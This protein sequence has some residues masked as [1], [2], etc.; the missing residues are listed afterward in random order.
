MKLL[1]LST[2]T[3]H[4]RYT[5]NLLK[6]KK[7]TFLKYLFETTSVKPNFD[8]SSNFSNKQEKFEK[9]NFFKKISKNIEKEKIIYFKNINDEKSYQ[10]LNQIKPDLGV[11]FGTRKIS[12][13][14]IR[15]FK[16]GLINIHRG[17][18][19]KYRGL[20]SEYWAIYHRDYKNI[21]ITIH[22]VN[23]GLDT[24]KILK[25]KRINIKTNHQIYMMRYLTTVKATKELI[26]II[27]NFK[28]KKK[29]KYS[30]IKS[31]GRYYSFIP[32]VIKKKLVLKAK[33][34]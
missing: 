27:N 16:F 3:A 30:K 23:T 26:E 25:Q 33:K 13:K 22:K 8:I 11:V 6:K 24:G 19:E 18:I 32:S 10:Y 1:F 15:L 5:I 7:I 29:F 20:D 31:Y 4:H 2:D 9:E 17:I 28:K 21:G 12:K 14:I 34:R